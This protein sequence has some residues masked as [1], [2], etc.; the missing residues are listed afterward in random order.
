MK[1]F[2]TAVYVRY[3][4][5]YFI[6]GGDGAVILTNAQRTPLLDAF[7]RR[8]LEILYDGKPEAA[9]MVEAARVR[10]D[11]DMKSLKADLTLPPDAT[12]SAALAGRYV[13]PDLGTLTVARQGSALTFDFGTLASAMATKRE[14]DGSLS[15]VTAN[16]EFAGLPV[17]PGK[18]ADGLR[19]LTIRDSQ[20]E[21]IYREAR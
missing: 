11:A 9:A 4:A 7:Q 17:V 14:T 5:L 15:F 10:F 13:H 20:H 21:Y 3:K 6:P 12:A 1:S 8:L 16:P 18:A 19:T 2:A